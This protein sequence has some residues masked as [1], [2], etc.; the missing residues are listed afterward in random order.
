MLAYLAA[1]KLF[2]IVLNTLEVYCLFGVA[3]EHGRHEWFAL[4]HLIT[5]SRNSALSGGFWSRYFLRNPT[6]GQ[7]NKRLDNEKATPWTIAAQQL[8][9]RRANTRW[10]ADWPNHP[11][12]WPVVVLSYVFPLQEFLCWRVRNFISRNKALVYLHFNFKS[13]FYGPIFDLKKLPLASESLPCNFFVCSLH[14]MRL[15]L[16]L[17]LKTFI[18]RYFLRNKWNGVPWCFVLRLILGEICS[19]WR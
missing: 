13:N 4:R 3:F 12:V 6:S 17:D 19:N 10:P 1:H 5:K 18:F 7:K 16:R 2:L 14:C 9:N 8:F 11:S 15:H